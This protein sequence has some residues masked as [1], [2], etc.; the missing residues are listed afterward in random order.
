[1]VCVDCAHVPSNECIT[2]TWKSPNPPSINK[3]N[4]EVIYCKINENAIYLKRE[5]LRPHFGLWGESVRQKW[6]WAREKGFSAALGVGGRLI[7]PVP[8]CPAVSFP[9]EWPASPGELPWG[10]LA[11]LHACVCTAMENH[12]FGSAI[13]TWGY[14]RSWS[15]WLCCKTV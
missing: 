3:G 7:H 5:M 15:C 8:P 1:M 12:W 6:E 10:K 4:R 14:M 2:Q 9:R 13:V 11:V